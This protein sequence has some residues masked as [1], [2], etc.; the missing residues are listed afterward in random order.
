MPALPFKA[1]PVGMRTELEV[2]PELNVLPEIVNEGVIYAEL[3]PEVNEPV[4]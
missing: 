3:V 1:Q 2:G 4:V